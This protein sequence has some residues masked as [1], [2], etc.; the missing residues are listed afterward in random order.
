MKYYQAFICT[1][2]HCISSYGNND[3]KFC[4]TCGA[5]VI[6]VCP[7]CGSPLRGRPNE[8]YSF[9]SNYATPDFC[10]NCGAPLPWTKA[11]LDAGEELIRD[12]IEL[13]TAQQ[14]SLI[15]HLPDII[16]ATPR[17]SLAGT[18][19]ARALDQMLDVTAAGMKQFIIDCAC[20]ALKNQLGL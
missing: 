1:N 4:E 16:Q 8:S 11:A 2:G 17:T 14:E 13:D 12:A 20:E 6:S 15:K 7:S 3:T 18:L 9:V 10:Y 19:V 5:E